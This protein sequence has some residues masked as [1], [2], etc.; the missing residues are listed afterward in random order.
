MA[1]EQKSSNDSNKSRKPKVRQPTIKSLLPH[2]DHVPENH[3][4]MIDIALMFGSPRKQVNTWLAAGMKSIVY[5]D[6]IFTDIRD[7]AKHYCTA[8]AATTR[9]DKN[10]YE[11]YDLNAERARKESALA[12]KAQ[13]ERDLMKRAV[14]K[15]SEVGE[16]VEKE[17][18]RV[19]AA[20]LQIPVKMARPLLSITDPVLIE[21]MLNEEVNEVLAHL[22]GRIK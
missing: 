11:F 18:N 10:D 17:Y 6:E 20:V 19:R 7:Y 2:M 3:F 9:K 22:S 16:G 14:V 8:V 1:L 21:Q 15:V 12:D 13:I 5:N 4:R